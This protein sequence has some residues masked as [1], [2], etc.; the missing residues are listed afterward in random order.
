MD[1]FANILS[2]TLKN[3]PRSEHDKRTTALS[4]ARD[5][6][7]AYVSI[8][9]NGSIKVS[10]IENCPLLMASL[11]ITPE[12]LKQKKD[13]D[14]RIQVNS[15]KDFI[16]ALYS[17]YLKDPNKWKTEYHLMMVKNTE[18]ENKE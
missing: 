10:L 3:N 14:G 6:G 13:K 8:Y 16:L 12:Y 9:S 5:R 18:K 7:W 4:V 1:D 11:E 17:Q 15:Y 2:S